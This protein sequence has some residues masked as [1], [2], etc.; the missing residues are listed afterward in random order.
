MQCVGICPTSKKSKI[1]REIVK[2]NFG[3]KTMSYCFLNHQPW[4]LQPVD[5]FLHRKR[6]TY[7]NNPTKFRDKVDIIPHHVQLDSCNDPKATR[8]IS[9]PFHNFLFNFSI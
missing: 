8:L 1:V 5:D 6:S 4:T 9:H 7:T 3:L 2:E